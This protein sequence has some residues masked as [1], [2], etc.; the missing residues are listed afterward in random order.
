MIT[1][2]LSAFL[3]IIFQCIAIGCMIRFGVP[4]YEYGLTQVVAF[5]W[6]ILAMFSYGLTYDT[7][8]GNHGSDNR[9]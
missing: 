3:S 7:Q 6:M 8:G 5:A 4:T 2:S 1:G 9:S